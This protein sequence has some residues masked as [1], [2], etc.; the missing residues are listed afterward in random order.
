[1]CVWDIEEEGEKERE[2]ERQ[3]ETE[4]EG[5]VPDYSRLEIWEGMVE[6]LTPLHIWAPPP[7]DTIRSLSVFSFQL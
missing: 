4:R 3:T 2:R 5:V 1:M 7:H 6:Y